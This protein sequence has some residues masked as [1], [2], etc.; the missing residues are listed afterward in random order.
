MPGPRSIPKKSTN[1]LIVDRDEKSR[2]ALKSVLAAAHPDYVF[3]FAHDSR[4]ALESAK[5]SP[6][7][8]VFLDVVM[9]D[10][11]GFDLC[12]LLKADERYKDVPLLI[13][14][15]LDRPESK[16][17]G[18]QLGASD[19]ILK[20][21]DEQETVARADAQLRMKRFQDRQKE[22]NDELRRMQSALLQS[23]KMSAAGTLAAGIAH[24][25]NN[26]LHVISALAELLTHLES[27]EEIRETTSAIRE[28]AQRGGRVA[29]SLLDFARKDEFQKNELVSV[30]DLLRHN[31]LLLDK[32]LRSAGITSSVRIADAPKITC[33]PGQ[34]AQVFVNLIY[35][36]IDAMRDSAEKKLEVTMLVC[37][38]A[39]VCAAD[40]TRS[41]DK[42]KGCLVIAFKD[43]GCGIPE[44]I[45]DRV[46]EPF[47]TTRGVVGG[48]SDSTPGTG[49]GLSISYG[50]IERHG[51][52]IRFDSEE[53]K[54][55]VFT[56]TLP[57]NA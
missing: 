49:L 29:K 39:S 28:C 41:H 23:S 15:A 31:V 51:G 4:E 6:P 21:I 30:G 10:N 18:F 25:F 56:I 50:I 20:P 5:D 48:G 7:D 46:F 2:E 32:S 13:I 14:T 47:F 11:E 33:F 3:H 22:L 34:L 44:A 37:D 16:L 40:A 9:P 55:T 43:T 45:R 52:Q 1:I 36:A 8:L 27:P 26:I 54:G 24:E 53:G 17:K 12:F 19:Y 57:I 42:G 35:N 38:C